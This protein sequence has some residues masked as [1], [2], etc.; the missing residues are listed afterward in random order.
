MSFVVT[1][2]G[3]P[4]SYKSHVRDGRDTTGYSEASASHEPTAMFPRHIARIWRSTPDTGV[5]SVGPMEALE[6]GRRNL[7]EPLLEILR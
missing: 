2:L 6:S 5:S 4:P 1:E 3:P 7:N